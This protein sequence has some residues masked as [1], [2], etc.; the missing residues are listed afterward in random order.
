MALI[1]ILLCCLL[2]SSCDAGAGRVTGENAPTNAEAR[3]VTPSEI[4]LRRIHEHSD[5]PIS[6]DVRALVAWPSQKVLE[7]EKASED[8][9]KE[10]PPT[11]ER[12]MIIELGAMS[13]EFACEAAEGW[14][15]EMLKPR[16][17]P[18][19]L[20]VK[21]TALQRDPPSRSIIVCRYEIDGN[22]IM[23][24]QSRTAMWVVVKLQAGIDVKGKASEI[25]PIMFREFF[26]KGKTMAGFK[27]RAAGSGEKTGD[28][29]ALHAYVSDCMNSGPIDAALE[30][31]GWI[32]WYTDGETVAVLLRKQGGAREYKETDTWF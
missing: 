3:E 17:L 19:D 20:T 6:T 7:S 31:W 14:I 9:S 25:G 10:F 13:P 15:R 24:N 26:T 8:R 21:L 11:V 18:E 28:S 16:W 1:A 30:W 23:I 27:G 5:F 32:A 4:L 22:T 2:M 12:G 29:G